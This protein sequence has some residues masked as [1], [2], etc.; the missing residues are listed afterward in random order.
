MNQT[1]CDNCKRLCETPN[2]DYFEISQIRYCRVQMLFLIEHIDQ[3][4]DGIY[5]RNPQIS[6]Y[7]DSGSQ[8]LSAS[9]AGFVNPI[10]IHGEITARLKACMEDGETLLHE[11][12]FLNADYY[13]AL[14]N[15]SKSALNYCSGN[16]RRRM[17]YMAWLRDRK[18]KLKIHKS[19]VFEK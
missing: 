12:R 4:A 16:N 15:A 13:E 7:Q 2:A 18:R 9:D 5:P 14:S 19:V 6:G 1:D 8:S 11:V 10:L 3:L 17:S